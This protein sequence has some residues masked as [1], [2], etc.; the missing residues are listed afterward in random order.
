M[1]V[2]VCF[3]LFILY[4]FCMG[5]IL[6]QEIDISSVWTECQ[7][8][9]KECDWRYRDYR[10]RRFF[11]NT[12]QCPPPLPSNLPNKI[13][14]RK[15]L[16]QWEEFGEKCLNLRLRLIKVSPKTLSRSSRDSLKLISDKMS[17]LSYHAVEC[18][19]HLNINKIMENKSLRIVA[20]QLEEESR[21][22]QRKIRIKNAYIEA[23][24]DGYEQLSVE[25][26]EI[27]RDSITMI[28]VA[29]DCYRMAAYWK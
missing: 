6:A 2:S 28:S 17:Y 1:K 4:V 10:E 8:L 3:V 5:E 12:S 21:N 29:L 24:Y 23:L 15:A 11:T 9:Q 13:Q 19:A 25:Q 20:K 18:I 27:R 22:T 14:K 7:A 16:K 26:Q